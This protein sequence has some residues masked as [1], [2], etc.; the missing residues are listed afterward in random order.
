MPCP[1]FG[2]T[3]S[4]RPVGSRSIV[5]N[6]VLLALAVLATGDASGATIGPTLLW[7]AA[8]G[9]VTLLSVRAAR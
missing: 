1:C 6:G 2:G 7:S 9:A 8:L 5:R 4:A 3:P